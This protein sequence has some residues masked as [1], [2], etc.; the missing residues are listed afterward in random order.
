MGRSGNDVGG[1]ALHQKSVE[2]ELALDRCGASGQVHW[3]GELSKTWAASRIVCAKKRGRW[4]VNQPTAATPVAAYERPG[5][6]LVV[7]P[8][9]CVTILGLSEATVVEPMVIERSRVD[10]AA[11]YA[12]VPRK[13]AA[14]TV[15]F[16]AMKAP[17]V[18]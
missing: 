2:R 14:G 1:V 3:M 17:S 6:A 9:S 8:P 10:G 16:N 5:Y 15:D 13:E 12:W 11:Q 18:V 4:L 7:P